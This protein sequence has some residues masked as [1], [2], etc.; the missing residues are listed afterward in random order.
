M[1][2]NAKRLA[3]LG[4]H[5]SIAKPASCGKYLFGVIC[6]VKYVP[7]K[8]QPSERMIFS[9]AVTVN[10]HLVFPSFG[11]NSSILSSAVP[12]KIP[13]GYSPTQ[14]DQPRAFSM[15]DIRPPEFQQSFHDPPTQGPST[16]LNIREKLQ[17]ALHPG[18]SSNPLTI[19]PMSRLCRSNTHGP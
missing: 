1:A 9:A 13:Y 6:S 19:K 11:F 7:G 14:L 3:E 12:V 4:R 18:L 5:D 2:R 15:I 16:A 8:L 10:L 17:V